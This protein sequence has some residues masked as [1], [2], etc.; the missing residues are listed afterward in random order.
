MR[1]VRL[2]VLKG[3]LC[4]LLGRM[5]LRMLLRVDGEMRR[6]IVRAVEGWEREKMLAGWVKDVDGLWT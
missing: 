6:G 1:M 2:S 5:L 4:W 3:W